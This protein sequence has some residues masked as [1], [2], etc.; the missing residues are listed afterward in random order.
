MYGLYRFIFTFFTAI[1]VLFGATTETQF[2]KPIDNVNGGDPFIVEDE[3]KTFYTFTTG[4]TIE[5]R[6]IVSYKDTTLLKRKTVCSS[7]EHGIA[8]HIWAPEIHKIGDKWYIVSCALFDKN[9]VP[10]G[11]MPK[12]EA[13]KEHDDFYRYGFVL[14][15]KTDDVFGEYVF[16][17][18]LAPDGL[19]NIDGTY[20]KKDGKLYYVTSAY[21]AVGHQCL[22]ICEMDNPYTLKTDK[23]GR[24]NAVKLSSP[25]YSWERQGWKVN[26]G[27]AVLY[28]GDDIF[29]VYS[30]SGYSSNKYCMGML[31]L[32]GDNVMC[33]L[34]WKK[35]S[36]RVSYHLPLKDI[37]SAGHCSFIHRD[38]GDIF[39]VYHA[40]KTKDFFESPRLTYIKK[41]DF[42]FGK[43][44]LM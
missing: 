31:T 28:Y 44:I 30:A 11:K 16:K 38:N 8:G 12:A 2:T 13:G 10:R 3:G 27:P 32:K 26:E 22:Y 9:A 39:M 33:R 6:R 42:A 20:L 15:S 5:I 17:G 4:S 35:S 1:M 23:K 25:V 18:Y 14:E 41:I 21:M 29:I 36:K 37:Y 7:G 24:H 40:N 43:P 34:N 19:N